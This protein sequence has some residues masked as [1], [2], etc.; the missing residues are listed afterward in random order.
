M[1]AMM[2]MVP[3]GLSTDAWADTEASSSELRIT[4]ELTNG[5]Q[6]VGTAAQADLL[7]WAP[8][9]SLAFTPDGGDLTTLEASQIVAIHTEGPASPPATEAVVAAEPSEPAKP[10]R[11]AY[12]SPGGFSH[13]NPAASRH[14]YA[15]SAIP[16]EQGQGYVSQKYLAFSSVAYAATDNLTLVVGAPTFFPPAMTILGGKFAGEVS[17]GVHVGAGVEVF[18]LPLD[19]TVLASIAFGAV[20]FGN[21]DKQLTIAT[22][23]LG[24]ELFEDAVAVP[25]MIGGQTRLSDSVAL[26]TENWIIL[27]TGQMSYEM[28]FHSGAVRLLG[29]RADDDMGTRRMRSTEG[30]PK[31]SWDLGMILIAGE[32]E[33]FG[34]LP[35]IDWTWH[36]G[37]SG[38]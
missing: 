23:M 15:P 16:M 8:G 14:L 38:I 25:V 24:G 33:L 17:E 18:M 7:T 35:W 1:A 19:S 34:P 3:M 4:V 31:T 32:G 21:A 27:D 30:F 13:P 26:I 5:V 37:P 12:A 10:T 20:T 9:Q 36:F 22:G 28:S 29:R 6:F 11:V 2:L